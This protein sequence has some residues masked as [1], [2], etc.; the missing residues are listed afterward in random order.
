MFARDV[1]AEELK[2]W[3]TWNEKNKRVMFLI[4]QNVSNGMI[5]HIQS[6][7]T[8]KEAWETLEK[9]Y[10]SN[11]KP[12]KIQLK[13]ELNNMKK[14]EST[15]V[16]DYLLKIKEITDA[17]GSIGAQPDDD[18]VVSATL[19][20]LKDDEKWKPFST[21]IYVRE[22]F[23]DFD[24]LKSLMIIEETN[25]GGPSTSKGPREQAHAFYSD[26]SRGRGRGFGRGRGGGRFNNQQ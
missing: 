16:N 10:H 2:A 9:L 3:K 1:T 8:S 21:S 25:M 24:E 26:N 14:A 15:S 19:N 7:G 17:L 22:N 18:D 4:S 23:P 12:T 20:G 6:V 13:K 5:R 11:T